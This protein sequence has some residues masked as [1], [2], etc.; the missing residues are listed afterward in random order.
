M[1]TIKISVI[2]G[3]V[4][5]VTIALAM[6]VR[7]EFFSN[8]KEAYFTPDSDQLRAV[9]SGIVMVRPTHF[10]SAPGKIRH[11]HNGDSLARTVGRNATL[12]DMLAEAYNC[13]PGRVVLPADAPKGHFDF[14]VTTPETRKHLRT[15]IQKETGYAGRHETREADVFVLTVADP[16]LPGFTV[17]ADDEESDINYKDG[18]LTFKHQPLKT[19]LKGLEDGLALPVQDETGLT[20]YYDFS[21]VWSKDIQ[22]RM[23]AGTF[24][25]DGV[26]RVLA[27]WGLRL[28]PGTTTLDMVIVEKAK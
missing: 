17:S 11:V 8:V 22:Q 16:R 6:V 4:L 28:E 23:Q 1:K 19:I 26:K 10:A 24:S 7:A 3:I 2:T 15:A 13:D 27:D 20:N 25:A 5:A 9:P 14:L 21:V 18:K 12:R